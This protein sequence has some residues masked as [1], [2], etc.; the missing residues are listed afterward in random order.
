[1][2]HRQ[3]W[4]CMWGALGGH[5]RWR[6]CMRGALGQLLAQS[7][8]DH[9][10][11]PELPG[12]GSHT[13]RMVQGCETAGAG[14]GH[15]AIPSE[16]HHQVIGFTSSRARDQP[17]VIWAACLSEVRLLLAR[18][19]GGLRLRCRHAL[20]A[21]DAPLT[22]VTCH[23]RQALAHPERGSLD[24]QP[25]RATERSQGSR[26]QKETIYRYAL[27]SSTRDCG[28]IAGTAL[29]FCYLDPFTPSASL[30]VRLY[31]ICDSRTCGQLFAER[32]LLS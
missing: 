31:T 21:V 7:G 11:I 6:R 32:S 1:M 22:R 29:R 16:I 24:G 28:R 5:R 10:R 8:H 17:P 26:N 27:R 9:L 12:R 13:S 25:G 20:E 23:P 14:L 2:P 19:A 18:R 4:R 15:W 30:P 3:W